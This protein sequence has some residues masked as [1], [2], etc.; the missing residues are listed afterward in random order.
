[1]KIIVDTC[2]W[3][4]ALRR[5][6][7]KQ[8]NL[9]FELS[10]LISEVRV[11]LIGPIRQ[12]LLSGI[13]TKNQFNKLK[14]HL[15]AFPDLPMVSKDFELA[16]EFYNVARSKGIQGSNTDFIICSLAHTHK[17]SIFTI[18][19]DFEHYASILPIKLHEP[20]IKNKP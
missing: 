19:K 11:Q 8:D 16:A 13:K 10:E 7:I 14:K 6:E 12:E 5:N 17:M 4:I 18:D 15:S 1:M 20:Q 9:I 2:I 3:S